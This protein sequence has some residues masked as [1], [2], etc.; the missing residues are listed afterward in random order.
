MTIEKLKK[1]MNGESVTVANGKGYILIDFNANLFLAILSEDD[2]LLD[3]FETMEEA[4]EA[5]EESED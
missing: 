4:I 3:C 5:I 2:F 1:L